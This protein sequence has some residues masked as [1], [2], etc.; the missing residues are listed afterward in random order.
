MIVRCKCLSGRYDLTLTSLSWFIGLMLSFCVLICFASTIINR[1][2]IFGVW[3]RCK[4]YTS[5][6]Q[7]SSDLYPI[8]T[9]H[10]PM[11]SFCGSVCFSSNISNRLTIFGVWNGCKVYMSVWQ[12]SSDL[13]LIF[14]VHWSMGKFFLI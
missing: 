5:V 13:D 11:L 1:L 8:L 6:W 4:V 3:N 9:V 12:V 10:W 7:L 2:T 14:M